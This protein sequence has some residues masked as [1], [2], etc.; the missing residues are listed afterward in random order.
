MQTNATEN[1][2]RVFAMGQPASRASIL[3]R[4]RAFRVG[5]SLPLLPRLPETASTR[6][7]AKQ[8]NQV[9]LI[10]TKMD[11][12]DTPILSDG[13]LLGYPRV[14]EMA[15]ELDAEAKS[16]LTVE[17]IGE[18]VRDYQSVV[19]LNLSELWALHTMLRLVLLEVATPAAHA[20][21][22]TVAEADWSEFV[23]ENSRVHEILLEDPAGFY[24][25]MDFPTRDRY[26]Q[27]VV[28]FSRNSESSEVT[29]AQAAI[30]LA[31]DAAKR[32]GLNSREAHVGFHLIDKGA[33]RLK[34]GLQYRPPFRI[35][36]QTIIAE[37]P[38]SFYLFG[39]EVFTLVLAFTLLSRLPEHL[40]YFGLI[41]FLLATEPA[42]A[43]M[44]LLTT[45][46]VP[47]RALP[48]L[49]FSEG[50]PADCQTMVIVPT[51]LLSEKFIAKLVDD[52]EI[53]YLANNDPNLTFALLTDLPDADEPAPAV[54][55][56][57]LA[58]CVAGIHKLNDRY[59]GLANREPFCLFH[60]QREWNETQA[61]WMGWERKRGKLI[62]LNDLLRGEA[63]TFPVK[64][65]DLSILAN[66][67]YVITLDS[68]TELPRGSAAK[69][70][71]TMAHPLNRAVIDP[72]TNM[73]V[74]GY[75]IL[76]PRVG[77]SVNSSRRSR[78][79]A[80]YSGQTGFDIYTTAV[81][82]IYQDIFGEGSYVGKGIYDVEVFQ[83]TLVKRFPHDILLSHDLIE[84]N[85]ARAGLVSDVEMIDDY[86]SHYTAWSKRKHR[87]VRGDW[88][89]MRW[90]LPRVPNYAGGLEPNPLSVIS[91]WKILD[92]LRR[93][94]IEIAIFVLLV[95]GWTSLPGGA[96]YWTA[97]IL[98]VSLLPVYIQTAFA[99]LRTPMSGQW[100]VHLQETAVAFV[101]GFFDI[102]LRFV[103]LAHQTCLML[104]AILRSIIR[105][106]VTG[107]RLLEWES[108]AQ[109][110]AG[111]ARTLLSIGSYLWL[112]T[113]LSALVAIL[114][115]SVNPRALPWALPLLI[116]WFLSPVVALWLNQSMPTRKERVRTQD[117]PFLR[118]IA[119]RTWQY[120][121]QY[122][123]QAD[124]WLIPDNVHEGGV[125]IAHRVSPTNL[126]L[127]LNSFLAARD[128][129]FIDHA[130]FTARVNRTLGSL[131]KMDRYRGH[132]YNWYDT[133]SLASLHPRYVSTVD[134]GN[135][136]AS[137]ITLRQGLLEEPQE[138]ALADRVAKL[139]DEMDFRFLLDAKRKLL[140]TGYNVESQTLDGFH[141]ALL[142]SEAR[143]AVFIAI[144]KNE[145]PNEAWLRLGRNLIGEG[146]RKVL[147]SWSGTMFEYFM[148]MLWLRNY[149]GSLLDHAVSGAVVTQQNYAAS[150]G[151]PW[152]VSECAS[153][154]REDGP[155]F[156]YHAFGVPTLALDPNLDSRLVIAPYA[157]VLA[158][159]THPKEATANLRRFAD[160]GWLSELGFFESADFEGSRTK[161]NIVGAF[162]AHHQGM[163]LLA[164]DNALNRNI[165]SKRFHREPM[166]QATELLLQER[167]PAWIPIE[168]PLPLAGGVDNSQS[169]S[170][171]AA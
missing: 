60:R 164:L 44:T 108:A 15:V 41:L 30:S 46:L 47:P 35:W 57:L 40:H 158:V 79:A 23:E 4:T 131:E 89:I 99:I 93:S 76:Q 77:I 36:L 151:V 121:A 110:E 16:E 87:W 37:W 125:F 98:I 20:S 113:P 9:R 105:T 130:E 90:L 126:G 31:S 116:A 118:E 94:L 111:G 147:L 42:I 123:T 55:A 154:E 7:L 75:G 106:T 65:C 124:N 142:G 5:R 161:A 2:R 6:F 74:E 92:N 68:D 22:Y 139:V 127:L 88:Q 155:E 85:Y 39:V 138:Y 91:L 137:L 18:F 141:Y 100:A 134:S 149:P 156:R 81:S 133:T 38:T 33:T 112:A 12:K 25:R 136:A 71:G 102:V 13:P 122:S 61:T 66:I 162:M 27:A 143:T 140:H 120:F 63:D 150:N 101:T 83:K 144:A 159:M 72:R 119:L 132:F 153:S 10:L 14:Y 117:R 58:F 64:I 56:R 34:A 80:I 84:G 52:L 97:V 45:Y 49:D 152:G 51:L 107:R 109:A 70:A 54:D 3:A 69:L 168:K 148:P 8:I 86:P 43:F 146:N 26:R 160:Y 167:I 82:D 145:I 32:L 59:R 62:A 103:F 95:A 19:P 73:V 21:L 166:I 170:K 50:I 78:L 28:E 104:D 115:Y 163:S 165:M 129:G 135:M 114:T 157:S 169:K 48:K 29:V 171:S 128:F 96:A 67:R 17:F 53:R 11:R 24:G 1:P